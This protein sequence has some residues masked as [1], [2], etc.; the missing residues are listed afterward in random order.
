MVVDRG[1][2]H[3][4]ARVPHVEAV[5]PTV[6][7]AEAQ[8]SDVLHRPGVVLG[9]LQEPADPRPVQ[10]DVHRIHRIHRILLESHTEGRP[11]A[12]MTS[13][14]FGAVKAAEAS[15]SRTTVGARGAGARLVARGQGL[16]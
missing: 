15:P 8:Q 11:S 10:R 2:S 7:Q 14:S 13:L 16:T 6:V 5:L 1:L 12:R 4:R 9:M 3:A